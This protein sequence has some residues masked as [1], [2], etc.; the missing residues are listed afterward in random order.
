MSELAAL[1]LALLA[2]I[3][4]GTTYFLALWW[5]VERTT[6]QR[7]TSAWLAGTVVLRLALAAVAFVGVARWGGWP[8]LGAAL[9]GFVLARSMLLRGL[10]GQH[11]P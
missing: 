3:A 4:L 10:H 1:G 9:A 11:A 5:S 8:A 7:R 2:G 6:R